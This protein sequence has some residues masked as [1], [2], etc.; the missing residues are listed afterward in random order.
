MKP[1]LYAPALVERGEQ[2]GQ[3]YLIGDD[4]G[5]APLPLAT[6]TR[7]GPGAILLDK[8][9]AGRKKA[10]KAM[11]REQLEQLAG[12]RIWTGRQA[13]ANGLVDELGTLEDA[14]LA[15]RDLAG[16]D[17]EKV[18]EL[19]ILPKARTLLD[20]LLE[21]PSS[22][23]SLRQ[24][25]VLRELPELTGHLRQ[26]EGLLRLRGEPVWAIVPCQVRVR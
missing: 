22:Q 17:K 15:A 14:V 5:G 6:G 10:G 2:R 7:P 9:L 11:T 18:P 8:A 13:K 12:G 19:L 21:G 23:M 24:L 3:A 1:I 25:P 26:A 4:S 16:M 20:T